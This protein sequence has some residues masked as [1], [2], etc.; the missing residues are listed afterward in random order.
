MSVSELSRSVQCPKCSRIYESKSKLYEHLKSYFDTPLTCKL[1]KTSFNNRVVYDY[2]KKEKFCR[3]ID[4]PFGSGVSDNLK[5]YNCQHCEESFISKKTFQLHTLQNHATKVENGGYLCNV[6][7]KLFNQKRLFFRHYRK[8]HH[9][10]NN[11]KFN[12]TDSLD[13]RTDQSSS[14]LKEQ[15]DHDEV[16]IYECELIIYKYIYFRSEIFVVFSLS[17]KNL[18]ILLRNLRILNAIITVHYF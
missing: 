16:I 13:G 11:A 3:N 5:K 2:H 15:T 18:E 12:V 1:C 7:E 4:I 6:C 17:I 10:E 9:R 8:C 14:K